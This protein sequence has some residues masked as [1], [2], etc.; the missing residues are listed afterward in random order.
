[1]KSCGLT[2]LAPAKLGLVQNFVSIATRP[3]LQGS[4]PKAA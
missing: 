1:M 3:K 4:E 2:G